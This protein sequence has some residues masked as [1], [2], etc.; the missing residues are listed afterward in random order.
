MEIFPKEIFALYNTQYK[1]NA[2]LTPSFVL[3]AV[4]LHCLG[5]VL[6]YIDTRFS[7]FFLLP[8]KCDYIFNYCKHYTYLPTSFP[9]Y[10]YYKNPFY[11]GYCKLS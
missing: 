4:I 9:P 6:S 2:S 8:C 11:L 7:E 10:I 3:C 5:N 1:L